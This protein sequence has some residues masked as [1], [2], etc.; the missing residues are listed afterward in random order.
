MVERYPIPNIHEMLSTLES[1][2]VFTTTDLSSAYHQIPLTHKSKDIIA[3]I[4]TEGLFH[5]TRIPL[6]LASVS[7]VFQRMMHKIIKDIKGVPYFQDNIL[8]HAKGQ[9]D[10]DQLLHT[11]LAHL[12][13]NGLMV[14][15]DKCKFNQTTVDYLGHTVTPDG[16]KP[17]ESLVTAVVDDPAPQNKD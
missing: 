9:E 17:K 6:G 4:T 11:V 1:A 14:Q 3:F 2:K 5:F 13:E 12:E 15:R 7:S 8:I 10:H 16:I